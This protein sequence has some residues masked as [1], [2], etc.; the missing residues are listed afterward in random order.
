MSNKTNV[1]TYSSYISVSL[2]RSCA[3]HTGN[4]GRSLESEAARC[5]VIVLETKAP[6]KTGRE[7]KVYHMKKN[8]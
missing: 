3:W 8:K 7:N 4:C 5:L 6:S 1:E 2:L